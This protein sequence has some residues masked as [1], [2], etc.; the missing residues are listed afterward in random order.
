MSTM[1]PFT[2]SASARRHSVARAPM[3][4][5]ART[6]PMPP[7][8]ARTAVACIQRVPPSTVIARA[9]IGAQ[10]MAA[11]MTARAGSIPTAS[12]SPS[13]AREDRRDHVFSR[14]TT[15]DGPQP[16]LLPQVTRKHSRFGRI[17]DGTNWWRFQTGRTG[18]DKAW[19]QFRSRR[20]Y[21]DDS[22]HDHKLAK[23]LES[24]GRSRPGLSSFLT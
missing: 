10:L 5:S 19:R 6:E 22:R 4:R 18:N 9:S 15:G 12:K 23:Q 8:R 2:T 3:W 24:S 16:T 7:L 14:K 21:A 17:L 11:G 13:R 1:W 20:W